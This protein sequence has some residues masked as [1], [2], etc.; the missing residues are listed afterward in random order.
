M[1]KQSDF[2][3]ILNI[4]ETEE[5]ANLLLKLVDIGELDFEEWG[6]AHSEHVT[7]E[8]VKSFNAWKESTSLAIKALARR[9][10]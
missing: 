6:L 5:I 1:D 2:E 10:K 7:D 3:D 8:S 9:I 4:L